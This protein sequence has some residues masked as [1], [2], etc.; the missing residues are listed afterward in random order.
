MKTVKNCGILFALLVSTTIFLSSCGGGS[1]NASPSIMPTPTPTP[2]PTAA[3]EPLPFPVVSENWSLIWSD[4]FD[5]AEINREDWNLELSC[6]GGG[7]NEKQCYTESESNAFVSDGLLNIV[8]RRED[9]TDYNGYD[10]LSGDLVTLP[11]TSARLT[12]KHHQQWTFGRFEFRAK[13]PFGQGSWPAV[14]MLPTDSPYGGW[15]ASGEIDIMEAVN[16]KVDGESRVHGTLHYGRSWPENVYSGEAYQLPGELNPADDFHIYA[17]EWQEGEIRWYVDGFHYATQRSSGWYSQYDTA[18]G[19]VNASDGAPFD[20][21]QQFHLLINFAVGGDWPEN[22]NRGGI[23][24]SAFPQTFLVDW[25]RVY[26][27]NVSPQSGEGC[28]AIGTEATILPGHSRPT[29]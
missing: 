28:A 15:A 2:T 16:L 20:S 7:N 12:T 26:E 11:Y 4:E 29:L 22:V 27:C 1:Q 23:D 14:W 8:A 21:D 17:L 3:P 18:A 6:W 13:L 25:I 9:H 10:G 24:E 5:G 19:L